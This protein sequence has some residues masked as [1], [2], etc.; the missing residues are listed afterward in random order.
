[1]SD[2]KPKRRGSFKDLTGQVFCRLTVLRAT[3]S[4]DGSGILWICK[5]ECGRETSASARCLNSGNTRSCGCLRRDGLIARRRTHGLSRK[6]PEYVVWKGIRA[7]C[8]N[9][10]HQNYKQYGGRGIKMCER[11]DDYSNFIFDM[12]PRP[13]PKHTIERKDNDSGYCPE[14]CKWET[15]KVQARNTRRTVLVEAFGKK[16]TAME[17][18]E[19][20]GISYRVI[21][22]R[23]QIGAMSV[24]EALT[25]PAGGD[26]A[27]SRKRRGRFR[28]TRG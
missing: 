12:G 6:A 13:T 19:E 9:P 4:A 25:W 17:W 2:F 27:M 28:T 14:N 11:W 16:M 1:M 20:T 26:A 10:K 5:C 15:R 24:E 3:R 22:A 18:A 7:R 8:N 23:L 21:K